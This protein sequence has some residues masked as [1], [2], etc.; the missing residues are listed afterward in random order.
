MKKKIIKKRP[1]IVIASL[2][3]V[4]LIAIIVVV[5]YEVQ[6]NKNYYG[7]YSGTYQPDYSSITYAPI[8]F[9]ED[10]F[11]NAEYMEK[12]HAIKYITGAQST[13][14]P[15]EYALQS[16]DTG[17]LFFAQYFNSIINGEHE[18]HKDFYWDEYFDDKRCFELPKEPFTKQKI[19]NISIDFRSTNTVIEADGTQK[20]YYIVRYM[21]FQ[22][23]GT[24]RRD[25]AEE[26][27]V[28]MLVELTTKGNTTRISKMFPYA[29]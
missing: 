21:I 10:I 23:N 29:G 13:E 24:F 22:N 27:T 2:F 9:E 6:T 8:D 26:T 16:F 11:L 20:S 12:N 17:L 19:H 4:F 5:I 18:V 7:Q 1:L 14:Y 15:I 3:A 28:P 25:L